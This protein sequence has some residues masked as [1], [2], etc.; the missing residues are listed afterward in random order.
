MTREKFAKIEQWGKAFTIFG[1][2]VYQ[3]FSLANAS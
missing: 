2:P 1:T 3:E